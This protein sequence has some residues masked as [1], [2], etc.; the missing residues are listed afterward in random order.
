M[1]INRVLPILLS[2]VILCVMVLL[3]AMSKPQQEPKKTETAAT[4][5]ATADAPPDEEPEMRG[6]WV[7]YMDLSMEEGSRSEG[8]FR[9]RIAH[10]AKVC[11]DSDFNTL[12][13][14]VRPFCDALYPS[15]LFPASHHG[16]AGRGSRL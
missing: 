6:V 16:K 2:A 14:Q 12:I 10:I 15:K 13:V 11:A 9:E 8:A 4:L 5:P 1:K 3:S 7:T